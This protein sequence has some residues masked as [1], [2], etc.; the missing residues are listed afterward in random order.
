MKVNPNRPK[1][2][3]AYQVPEGNVSPDIFKLPCVVLAC[4][5]GDGNTRYTCTSVGYYGN[6]WAF[7]SDYICKFDN[8]KWTVLSAEEYQEYMS[9]I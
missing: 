8:G 4:K 9:N 1:I 5:V 3:E 7:K 6:E 2:I